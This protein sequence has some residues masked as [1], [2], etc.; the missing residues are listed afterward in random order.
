MSTAIAIVVCTPCLAMV[1]V[2]LPSASG[3]RKR[4]VVRLATPGGSKSKLT[5]GSVVRSCGMLLV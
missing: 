1:S 4:D 5:A 2:A 3:T